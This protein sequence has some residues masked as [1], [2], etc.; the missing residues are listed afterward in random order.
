MLILQKVFYNV[1]VF[2]TQAQQCFFFPRF[3][4]LS[5]PNP[6][7]EKAEYGFLRRQ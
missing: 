4:I 3:N 5:A 6:S 7:S 2:Q 1:E